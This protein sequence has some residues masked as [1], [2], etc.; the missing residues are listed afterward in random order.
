MPTI[1]P[2]APAAAGADIGAAIAAAADPLA[3]R[4]DDHDPLMALIG[5]AGLVLL[6][7]AS[8]GTREFYHERARI[9]QRLIAEQGFHAVA[10]E[11]DWP[12]AHRVNRYVRGQGADRDSRQ[13]LAGFK[14]FPTWMWRND[15]VARF[16]DWLRAYNGAAPT[17]GFYGLD[18]Y[19]MFSSI[20]EVLRYL[21]GTDPAAARRARS[22]YACFDHFGEDSQRYGYTA[23]FGLS[24]SCEGAVVAQLRELQARAADY[25]H[26]DG[27]EAADAYF[28][29]QQNAKLVVHA[30]EYYRSMFHS[31]VRSWNL[32]DLHMMDTLDALRQ[33]LSAALGKP[34]RIVVW[35]HNSHIGDARATEVG[36]QGEWNVGQLARQRHGAAVRL[37]GLT[38]YQGSVT[39]ASDWHGAAERKRVRPALAGSCEEALHQA[40][41]ARFMLALNVDNAATRALA[42]PRLERA[43]GVIYLPE[44]ERQSHY[45]HASLPRQFDAVLHFDHTHAVEPL[46]LSRQWTAGEAPE[47]FPAGV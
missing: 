13:A 43:I 40:G 29:A 45:F 42:Q 5:D 34:A 47:T 8:H 35:E 11:A 12:D 27:A 4:P 31:R 16:V 38:T 2:P 23:G 9:T 28:H 15:D 41:M 14:R 37:V 25:P 46:E 3:G 19:S 24:T 32:R 20:D 36:A 6:G 26:G 10:V 21:D 30:E 44:T 7:E 22:R 17:V 33:H 39:A 18:L 1:P